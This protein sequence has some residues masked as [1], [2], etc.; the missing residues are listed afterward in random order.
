ME[1]FTEQLIPEIC[2]FW[3]SRTTRNPKCIKRTKKFYCKPIEKLS[4]RHLINSFDDS[5]SSGLT[6]YSNTF[7]QNNLQNVRNFCEIKLTFNLFE[8][9]VNNFEILRVLL[10]LC[11]ANRKN[12]FLDFL[13]HDLSYS[14]MIKN[15]YH[16]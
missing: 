8:Q 13:P 3:P 14:Y 5:R 7:C 15:T 10:K 1:W 2:H 9:N 16:I 4:R 11:S 6:V 12:A